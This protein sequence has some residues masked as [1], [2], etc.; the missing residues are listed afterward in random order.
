MFIKGVQN[1]NPIPLFM[2]W[3]FFYVSERRGAVKALME[4]SVSRMCIMCRE[5][6]GV[7]SDQSYF[8]SSHEGAGPV[9]MYSIF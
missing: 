5:D 8:C 7:C 6:M 9:H 4:T 1:I 2:Y 3:F